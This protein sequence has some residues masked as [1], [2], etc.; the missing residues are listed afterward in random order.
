MIF[1]F[2]L[3]LMLRCIMTLSLEN[4]MQETCYDGKE[5]LLTPY[6]WVEKG[7]SCILWVWSGQAVE[8]TAE[9]TS[10]SE[11]SRAW[12]NPRY[13]SVGIAWSTE[14]KKISRSVVLAV[15]GMAALW[16]GVRRTGERV[17]IREIWCVF[18]YSCR[19]Q[20]TGMK[21]RRWKVGVRREMD[22]KDLSHLHS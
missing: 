9:S 2:S 18:P 10:A 4:K 7:F 3:P 12:A 11:E 5:R 19:V 21:V 16:I 8:A 17:G 6:S 13:S 22:I 15:E 20:G 1:H 14:M